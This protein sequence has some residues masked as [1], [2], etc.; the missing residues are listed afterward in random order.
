MKRKNTSLEKK[1]EKIYCSFYFFNKC[2]HFCSVGSVQSPGTG[3]F[4]AHAQQGRGKVYWG[5]KTRLQ[6]NS[7]PRE[8]QSQRI[9]RHHPC[10]KSRWRQNAIND[11]VTTTKK[12]WFMSCHV[13]SCH[14]V[15]IHWWWRRRC[16]YD[17][18]STIRT[19]LTFLVFIL[20][21][22]LKVELSI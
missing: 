6:D 4:P 10:R 21:V 18:D 15:L 13:M 9:A 22:L 1:H 14:V 2:N 11:A 20:L 7:N 19:T 5:H 8:D 16:D 17:V 12:W 3:K